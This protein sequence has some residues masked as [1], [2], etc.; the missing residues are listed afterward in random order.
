MYNIDQAR[1]VPGFVRIHNKWCVPKASDVFLSKNDDSGGKTG[2]ASEGV[3]YDFYFTEYDF[4]PVWSR[5]LIRTLNVWDNVPMD[6]KYAC[7]QYFTYM[8]FLGFI[9]YNKT[10]IAYGFR[11]YDGKTGEASEGV[12][13]DFYFTEYDFCPVWSRVLIR[14]HCPIKLIYLW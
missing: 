12:E 6:I 9:R 11:E 4:C 14:T 1:F 10:F 13:Y 8:C 5:V 7:Q 3:E 2:E